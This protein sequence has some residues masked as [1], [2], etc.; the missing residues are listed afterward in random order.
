[1]QEF[2]VNN[3][4]PGV[5]KNLKDQADA[6]MLLMTKGEKYLNNQDQTFIVIDDSPA[7]NVYVHVKEFLNNGFI[8]RWVPKLTLIS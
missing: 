8:Y 1:M 5:Q 6:A 4:E 3:Y 7:G 2:D